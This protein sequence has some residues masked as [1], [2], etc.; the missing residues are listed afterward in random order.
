MCG[1]KQR[2]AVFCLMWGRTLFALIYLI[3]LSALYFYTY[4]L[5]QH[6]DPITTVAAALYGGGAIGGT[7]LFV[8]SVCAWRRRGEEKRRASCDDAELRLP[9]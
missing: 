6:H 2:I 3:L 7:I 4:T 1:I 5:T 9:V 8:W